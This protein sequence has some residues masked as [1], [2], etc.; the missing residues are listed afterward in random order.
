MPSLRYRI[1]GIGATVSGQHKVVSIRWFVQRDSINGDGIEVAL[2]DDQ[3]AVG[4]QD[5]NKQILEAIEERRKQQE[6]ALADK[7][8]NP[9]INQSLVGKEG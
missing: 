3:L 7:I 2:L 9:E 4:P 5:T 1:T 6:I 8:P